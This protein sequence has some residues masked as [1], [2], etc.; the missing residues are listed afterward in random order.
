MTPLQTAV[1]AAVRELVVELGP[2]DPAAAHAALWPYVRAAVAPYAPR[3]AQAS[4]STPR[5]RRV[6]RWQYTVRFW[7]SAGELVAETDPE[8]M[9]GT[10]AVPSI[11]A[12]LAEELHGFVPAELHPE[13]TKARLPQL[14]NNLGRG[15]RAALR[16]PYADGSGAP[17][18]CQMD[19][20]RLEG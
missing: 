8:Q 2:L 16:I 7:D 1:E 10:G 14:R 18:V 5:D 19:I 9:E 12:A 11:I 20:H 15:P 3:A 6:R 17:H 4:V 13:V